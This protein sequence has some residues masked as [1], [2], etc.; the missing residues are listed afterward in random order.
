[1][2]LIAENVTKRIGK[3]E[4]LKDVN[5]TMEPGHI[6]GF[7]GKN[8]S[9]KTMLFRVLSGLMHMSS[10]EIRLDNQIL[11]EDIKV[12]PSLGLIIENAGLYPEL[13][14][15][16]NLRLL[17][18]INHKIGDAEICNAIRRVGLDPYD[19]RSF[20]K[21]S[22]GMKQRIIIAQAIMETP[23]IIM[24]DEPTNAL[25]IEGVDEIR[26]IIMEEKER[27][28]LILIAS[29]NTD[30]ITLLADTVYSVC[31]GLIEESGEK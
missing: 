1:M 31:N 8:G 14:G 24:L 22:L 21:Y 17:A 18:K 26:N 6:Y 2:K 27:G 15:L 3:K 28:A 5:L 13:T 23:D 16:N 11:H 30:D 4:I 9:G 20:R 19:K 29:H 7:I 12:L 25:D 10:G